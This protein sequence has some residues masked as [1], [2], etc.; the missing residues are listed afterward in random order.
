MKKEH[1]DKIVDVV[2]FMCAEAYSIQMRGFA[3]GSDGLA[4]I[5]VDD[6]SQA[7]IPILTDKERAEIKPYVD[8]LLSGQPDIR[9]KIGRMITASTVGYPAPPKRGSHVALV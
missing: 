5:T 8:S 9:A 1:S 4:E 6:A 2:A 7:V 3:R